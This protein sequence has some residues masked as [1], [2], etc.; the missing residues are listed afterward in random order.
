[1]VLCSSYRLNPAKQE[2]MEKGLTFIPTPMALN[3]LQL[4]KDLYEYHRRLKILN[5]FDFD[6][7]FN[8]LPFQNPSLWESKSTSLV[9]QALMDRG[10]NAFGTLQ[11]LSAGA[12]GRGSRQNITGDQRRALAVLERSANIIVKPADKDQAN[13]LFE[14]NR[15]LDDL[16]YY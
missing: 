2:I 12:G 6:R 5:F 1:M 14:A 15:Q 8:H 11:V 3:K 7:D 16:N 10:L 9:W 13:Y 4:R